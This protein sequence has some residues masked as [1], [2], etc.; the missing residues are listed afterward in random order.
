T[1]LRDLPRPRAVI[2]AG[3]EARFIRAMLEPVC[4]VPFVAW[5]N[6]GLPGG[7]GALAAVWLLPGPAASTIA[8]HAGSRSTILLPTATADAL[9]AAVV[10]LSG[11]RELQLGP[12]VNPQAGAARMDQG[13]HEG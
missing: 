2:A 8:E 5:T 4:P 7:G 11:L 9:A 6:P 13:A 3:S 10:V 12:E 1:Q